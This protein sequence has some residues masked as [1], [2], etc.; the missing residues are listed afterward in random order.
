MRRNLLYGKGSSMMRREF[1][2][3]KEIVLWER[4]LYDEKKV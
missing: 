2:Y 1:D 3:E 4:K